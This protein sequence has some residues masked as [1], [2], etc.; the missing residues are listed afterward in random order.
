MQIQH[1][2]SS[3]YT[4]SFSTPPGALR[5][6]VL[7]AQDALFGGRYESKGW[8]FPHSQQLSNYGADLIRHVHTPGSFIRLRRG[9]RCLHAG[10]NT[11][12]KPN[13]NLRSGPWDEPRGVSRCPSPSLWMPLQRENFWSLAFKWVDFVLTHI[14]HNH[15][16]EFL[17][18]DKCMFG[19][20]RSTEISTN[21][22]FDKVFWEGKVEKK[23][24]V[25]DLNNQQPV[26]S[27]CRRMIITI[28]TWIKKLILQG[29][30][31]WQ[32][33]TQRRSPG[34]ETEWE[35]CLRLISAAARLAW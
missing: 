26:T 6:D 29:L 32:Q 9:L 17:Q 21:N 5:C 4:I 8:D 18:K 20:C 13:L 34:L 1:P 23:T 11:N 7:P 16:Y 33:C 31:M 27:Y 3:G 14:L 22:T 28:P 19:P 30:E 2:P 15:Q 10:R 35:Q 12:A 24:T 25:F